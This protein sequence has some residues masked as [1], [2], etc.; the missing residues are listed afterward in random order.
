MW[1]KGRVWFLGDDIDTDQIMPARYL[2][3]RTA[4]ALGK[5][6][7]SGND[8]GWAERIGAGDILIAGANFGCGSSREHAPLGLKGMGLACVV[9]RSFARIFYRNA[10]NIGLPLLVV[11]QPLGEGPQ[12]R[13]GWVDLATGRLSFDEGHSAL[14]GTPPAPI[15]LAI[16]A[17]GGLMQYVAR[18]TASA[19]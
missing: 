2:A 3:L 5:H 19:R 14:E 11:K 1:H 8:P 9:A 4:D 17:A 13:D 18:Q 12:G 16:L 7:L 6:A 15:V 10:V